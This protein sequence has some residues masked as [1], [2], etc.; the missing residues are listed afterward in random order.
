VN[1]DRI[2]PIRFGPFDKYCYYLL[3]PVGI[4]GVLSA[5]LSPDLMSAL[6]LVA[7]FAVIIGGIVGV[8]KWSNRPDGS[9]DDQFDVASSR[10]DA[11]DRRDSGA[12]P[13]R[14]GPQPRPVSGP[15]SGPQDWPQADPQRPAQRGGPQP[16]PPQQ[17]PHP[18]QGSPRPQ[19]E[20]PR[21]PRGPQGPQQRPQQAQQPPGR[22]APQRAGWP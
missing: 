12:W 10:L 4:V 2:G 1:P 21:P 18:Q 6:I 5:L 9:E 20:P 17:P 7:V 19:Q 11:R 3:V 13:A 15:H 8:D 14:S 22:P 16:R